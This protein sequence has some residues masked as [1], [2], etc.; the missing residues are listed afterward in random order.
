MKPLF[1]SSKQTGLRQMQKAAGLPLK[2]AEAY[3]KSK[4][5]ITYHGSGQPGIDSIRKYGVLTSPSHPDTEHLGIGSSPGFHTGPKTSARER[6]RFLQHWSKDSGGSY[7]HL[8]SKPKTEKFVHPKP[9]WGGRKPIPSKLDIDSAHEV[10]STNPGLDPFFSSDMSQ[11]FELGHPKIQRMLKRISF[12]PDK[13]ER[14]KVIRNIVLGIDD[15]E[16]EDEF[17]HGFHQGEVPP[18]IRTIPYHYPGDDPDPKQR[19]PGTAYYNRPKGAEVLTHALRAS[20]SPEVSSKR[21]RLAK[22]IMSLR[23]A[24]RTTQD[25]VKRNNIL[26][27]LEKATGRKFS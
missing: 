3:L 18:H 11:S 4:G 14:Y 8:Y 10:D 12:I 5:K 17:I 27:Q 15:I 25:P 16:K 13:Q 20:R 1:E 19:T 23:I 7:K 21:A 6:I 26:S 9:V 22:H 24:L 2:R